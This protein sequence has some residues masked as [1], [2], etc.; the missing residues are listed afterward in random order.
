[1]RGR[2][3]LS[4]VLAGILAILSIQVD[5]AKA[6]TIYVPDDYSRIQEAVD[7]ANPGDTIIVR[8]GTYTENVKV[9]KENLTIGTE[10]GPDSTIVQAA[11]RNDHVFG[12]TADYTTI[13]GFTIKNAGLDPHAPGLTY[14]GVWVLNAGYCEISNNY[15]LD[16]VASVYISNSSDNIITGNRTTNHYQGITISD[17][18]DSVISDNRVSDG[19]SGILI[20]SSENNTIRNNQISN[21]TLGM[22]LFGSSNNVLADNTLSDNKEN[23]RVYGTQLS[24]YVNDISVSN[25]VNGKPIHYLIG[26]NGIVID[27]SWY[28]GYLGIVNSTNVTIRNLNLSHNSQGLLLAYSSN[29]TIED[30]VLSDNGAGINLY[31]SSNNTITRNTAYNNHEGIQLLHSSNNLI[32]LN[33]FKDNNYNAH[34]P[35]SSNL[36][37][38]KEDLTYTYKG[39]TYTSPLGNYWSDY[40][41]I[42]SAGDGIGDPPYK[43]GASSGA[44]EG[45]DNHPLMMTFENYN[46]PPPEKTLAEKAAEL[47]KKVIGAAYKWGAK[48]WDKG[49]KV[50]L[51]ASEIETRAYPYYYWNSVTNETEIRYGP[52]IDCAGLIFWAYNKASDATAYVE[53]N[54][55]FFEGANGQRD[56]NFKEPRSEGDLRPGDVMFFD[57]VL[58]SDYT[59]PQKDKL[60]D[61]VAIYVGSYDYPGGTIGGIH[62]TAGTYDCVHASFGKG[63]VVPDNK[64]ML[65]EWKINGVLGFEGFRRWTGPE[66]GL[67]I[68]KTKGTDLC[69]TDPEGLTITKKVYNDMY[70]IYETSGALYYAEWDIDGDDHLD[71]IVI[72]PV[73]KPGC[74]LIMVVPEPTD[75]PTGTYSLEVTGNG[76]NIVLAENVQISNIPTQPYIL[77]CTDTEVIPVIPARIDFKPDTVNL[78]SKGQWVTVYIELPLGHGYGIGQIDLGT[79]ILNSLIRSEAK[80]NE[81]GDYDGDGIPDLMVKFNGLDVQKILNIGDAVRI[82]LTGNLIDG[83]LF[84]GTDT[85]RVISQGNV[86]PM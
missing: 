64:E 43:P 19:Y 2:D 8:D 17:T 23:F 16:N 25:K 42:D 26:K 10:N 83:R 79:L 44:D 20:Q 40:M 70:E 85:I 12:I 61:H 13:D 55:V 14:S 63:G 6:A 24:D 9:N 51:N 81:I 60:M 68:K 57:F 5:N 1:M 59:T 47:A 18:T 77:R 75:Y 56:H 46:E 69:V 21:H 31:E 4:V 29:C 33:N 11:N 78:E 35:G 36:W 52:G 72:A 32:F 54:P 7:A 48:G 27:S 66:V 67:L 71:D 3:S 49:L 22:D 73:R 50:F 74:Y 76:E 84:E 62:Y 45:S 80:P 38:S 86:S 53:T 65:K 28:V 82:T 41:G 37:N 58:N 34:C 30:L 15:F 39:K